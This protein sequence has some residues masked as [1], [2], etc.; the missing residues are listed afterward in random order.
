MKNSFEKS[1]F[2]HTESNTQNLDS[3]REKYIIN[4]N[5]LSKTIAILEESNAG[6]NFKNVMDALE[7]LKSTNDFEANSL[8]LLQNI[9]E[10][11]PENKE[12]KKILA[13]AIISTHLVGDGFKKDLS[14]IDRYYTETQVDDETI[15]TAST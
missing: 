4:L 7:G 8:R 9:E 12:G 2:N 11:L 10:Q 1:I 15:F 3:G 13:K 6:L 5:S 14:F